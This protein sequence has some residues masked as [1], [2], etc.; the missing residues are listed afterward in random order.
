MSVEC[1][2]MVFLVA[3]IRSVMENI[4]LCQ[5]PD[6]SHCLL[7]WDLFSIRKVAD[8]SNIAEGNTHTRKHIHPYPHTH[9]SRHTRRKQFFNLFFAR[10]SV[11]S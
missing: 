10:P 7:E 1:N 6:M 3:F 4:N 8:K 5:L 11:T 9:T 2:A